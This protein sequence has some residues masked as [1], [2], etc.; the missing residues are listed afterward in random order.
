MSRILLVLLAFLA[1]ISAAGA[2]ERLSGEAIERAFRGNTV[3]GRYA[4]GGFFTEYHDPDGRA[5][6][7]NGW[8]PNTDACW[9]TKPDR[10]CYYYGPPSDRTVHCFTVEM[11]GDL[12]V[13]RN[14]ANGRVNALAKVEPGNPR[15]HGDNG[16][17]WYCD[18]LISHAPVPPMSRKL[19]QR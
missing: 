6:G 12:Y 19:A 10:I 14:V 2:V 8:Q 17:S 18:G 16:T 7:H 9:I 4:S 13:L 3:S 5:L 15:N 1:P 11:S